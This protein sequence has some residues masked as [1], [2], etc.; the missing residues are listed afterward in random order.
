MMT[1]RTLF[2]EASR[3]NGL[4]GV[5]ANSVWE[6]ILYIPYDDV[7]TKRVSILTDEVGFDM[8]G[9]LTGDVEKCP[10]DFIYDGVLSTGHP[11]GIQVTA[12]DSQALT[13]QVHSFGTTKSFVFMHVAKTAVGAAFVSAT[14]G[15]AAA[16]T[17]KV[18]LGAGVA[19]VDFTNAAQDDASD[20]TTLGTAGTFGVALVVDRDADTLSLYEADLG[21]GEDFALVNSVATTNGTGVAFQL[22]DPTAIT[23]NPSFSLDTYGTL[24]MAT[25]GG[26]ALP[27]DLVSD[28]SKIGKQWVKGPG[29]GPLRA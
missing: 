10:L 26:V 22:D 20:T 6:D 14:M 16:A 15:T 9:K 2:Q 19:V 17:S 24:L 18:T 4:Y 21:A 13:H 3:K 7:A 1:I 27:S 29:I 12:G 28:L 25:D 8:P 23:I 5:K 11:R